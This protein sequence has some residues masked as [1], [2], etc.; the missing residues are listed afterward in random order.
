MPIAFLKAALF[1]LAGAAVLAQLPPAAAQNLFEPVIKVNDQAIT[2]FEVEQRARM[3][4]LFRAPGNPVE[5]AREQLIEDRLKLDAAEANGLRIDEG[6]L[7]VAMEEFAN[8]GDMSADE[9]VDALADAG[10]EESTFRAF[11]RSGVTWRELVRAK[12]A[13][14]VS[15]DEEDI[16]RA[17]LALSGTSGVRVLL[18][19]I[20]LPVPRG[21]RDQVQQRAEE[22]SAIESVTEFADAARRYS[23]APSAERGGRMDWTPI[24]E[25]P[26]ALRSV[27]LGLSPGEVSDPLTTEQ[28][29][30]LLQMRDIAETAVPEPSYSAIEYAQ[31]FIDGGRSEAALQR[32]A[33]VAAQVDTCDD[34]YGV[35]RGQSP[36]R[37]QRES[38]APAE[39]PQDI[40]RELERLDPG[41]VSTALT[42]SD[43]QVLVFLMLCGRTPVIDGDGP[44][45]DELTSF[46]RNK[47][48]ESYAEG[49]LA[50]L[51][52][53]ARIVEQ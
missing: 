29:I 16:E 27:V 52:A 34:L 24:T 26:E 37:L 48:L 53:E 32:A 31:Y 11:V 5:L 25:L 51:R 9:M 2:R 17:K 40:S 21:Q 38:K 45:A 35:A 18:S 46:I 50:Q 20:V 8:R 10:V 30:V 49:Y 33:Q 22:L 12:F 23:A 1:S 3:L 14:Q 42:R 7:D 47:R 6:A 43:G 19:E 41:E 44:S 36:D 39:I 28:A 15:V 4:T 13:G